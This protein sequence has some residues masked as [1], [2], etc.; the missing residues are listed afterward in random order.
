MGVESK[1]QTFPKG[2]S[3]VELKGLTVGN[4]LASGAGIKGQTVKSSSQVCS[5]NCTILQ[6]NC[7]LQLL[8]MEQQAGGTEVSVVRPLQFYASLAPL[9]NKHK[10]P[11]SPCLRCASHQAMRLSIV[12]EHM[13]KRATCHTTRCYSLSSLNKMWCKFSICLTVMGLFVSRCGSGLRLP[14]PDIV[15]CM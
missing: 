15:C 13:H 14:H 12:S 4:L 7:F 8:H 11:T 3:S 6:P 1:A 10:L 2:A 9:P 5:C